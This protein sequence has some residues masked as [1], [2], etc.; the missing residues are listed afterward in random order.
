MKIAM[1]HDNVLVEPLDVEAA[2]PGGVLLPGNAKLRSFAKGRAVAVGQGLV[3]T[4]GVTV[5]LRIEADDIAYYQPDAGFDVT[6][7]GVEYRVMAESEIFGIEPSEASAAKAATFRRETGGLGGNGGFFLYDP[8]LGGAGGPGRPAVFGNESGF[9]I[10]AGGTG[11]Q[12]PP[13]LPE[14]WSLAGQG[15]GGGSGS[16]I[17]EL[18]LER[19]SDKKRVSGKGNSHYAA[20]VA[21]IA[22]IEALSA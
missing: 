11:Y 19:G 14:G 17:Y 2:T 22:E 21:A 15:A 10:G 20:T 16:A 7:G 12:S 1:L 6:M 4:E 3:T 18:T 9:S 8:P 13:P 5:P